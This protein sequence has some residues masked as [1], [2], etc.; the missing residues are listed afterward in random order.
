MINLF[1]SAVLAFI[2]GRVYIHWG[3]SLSNRR[4]FASNF[5]LITITTTFIILVVRSMKRKVSTGQE[6]LVGLR[7][8]VKSWSGEDGRVFVH[9]EIWRARADGPLDQG[10]K[11]EVLGM[12]GLELEVRPIKEGD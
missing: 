8:E 12:N 4:K 6:G 11:I 2:L 7:G 3:T 9:G 1:L 5:M 10:A